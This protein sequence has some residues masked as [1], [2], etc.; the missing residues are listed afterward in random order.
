MHHWLLV[1][2]V[3]VSAAA[4]G[5]PS[6]QRM[7]KPFTVTTPSAVC[8]P[9]NAQPTN[10]ASDPEEGGQVASTANTTD[11]ASAG[12]WHTHIHPS[13]IGNVASDPE[14]GGQATAA[15]TKATKPSIGE[16]NVTKVNDKS[17]AK[18]AEAAPPAD[19]H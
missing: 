18:L 8:A 9:T 7:H 17:S 10:V 4:T 2:A 14:E 13:P 16:I 6:G 11:T 5:A 12:D 1:S 3:A 15:K 19:C